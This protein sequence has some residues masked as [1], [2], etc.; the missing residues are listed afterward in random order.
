MVS[1][2]FDPGRAVF[3]ALLGSLL[4]WWL[5]LGVRARLRRFEPL[6]SVCFLLGA[7]LAVAAVLSPLERLGEQGLVTAHVTQHI[8]LGDVAAPLL[9]LGLPAAARGWLRTRLLAL[10][11]AERGPRAVLAR[12]LSPVGALVIWALATYAWFVPPLHRLAVPTGPVHVLDHLS[13]LGFGLLVW[14][15]PFDPRPQ[16]SLREGLRRGGLP[17]WG[18][19][20]YAMTSRLA[21]LFPPIAVWLASGASYHPAGV[22]L[23]FGYSYAADQ[24]RA[25]QVI[26]GFEMLLFGLAFVLAFIFLAI[27][28]GRERQASGAR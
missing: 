15:I 4:V 22:E 1:V 25:A 10:G 19:H 8:V 24:A 23:P 6:R 18:R 17:W 27:A 7:G 21:M 11:R 13:F 9:L 5:W 14:L 16:T 12:A 28:E 26:V 3:L 2:A 20:I